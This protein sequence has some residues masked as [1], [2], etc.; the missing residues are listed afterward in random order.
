MDG[1][2]KEERNVPRLRFP[3]FTGE[4]EKRKLGELVKV[5]SGCDYKHLSKG[6]IPV[7][8]TGGYMTSVNKALSY[9]QDAVGIGRKGTI[10]KPYLLKAP[11]W[12]VDTLFFAIPEASVDINFI[13]GVFL[14][15]DWKQKDESTGV[16]SLS[17]QTINSVDVF[18]P[19]YAEQV[20]I[21]EKLSELDTL[22]A[23]YQQKAEHLQKLKRGLLQKMFPKAGSKVPEIRFP[24][25]T[26]EWEQCKVGNLTDVLSA[27]RVHR[28][29]WDVDG[30]PF[31]R[32]SDV[33]A[34]FK[35]IENKK[36]FIPHSLYER[37]AKLSGKLE[38][39]DILI[40]GGGSIGI[41]YIVPDGMPLYSKDA[42]LIWIKHSSKFSS[43]YLFV[44][45]ECQ[46]F[47][48]Y[49]NS[50]SHVGTIAHYTIEQVKDTPVMLPSI[51]EQYAVG[52]HFE[53][54]DHLKTL[55]QRNLDHLKELKKGLLQQMFV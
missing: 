33:I 8:G 40:T 19:G 32:S 10:D 47:R 17:K 7:Y 3:G 12:T 42:D 25:F 51:N 6:S 22:I 9:E 38:K 55:Y 41:P 4:W 11:F 15:V 43:R 30:V 52:L 35:G 50:I 45:F 13:L 21:G 53:K 14:K 48:K 2:E 23:L 20:K 26:G 49:I 1:K 5:C 37:L 44:Y 31:F 16:P 39:N 34:A 29:E 24:E 54:L 27:V 28:G 36:V 46:E 18:V